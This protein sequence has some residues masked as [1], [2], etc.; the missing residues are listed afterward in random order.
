MNFYLNASVSGLEETK[1]IIE[2][3]LYWFNDKDKAVLHVFRTC[4]IDMSEF[5]KAYPKCANQPGIIYIDKKVKFEELHRYYCKSVLVNEIVDYK[6]G[7]LFRIYKLVNPVAK[8][9]DFDN[10]PI[11]IQYDAVYDRTLKDP[12]RG[13]FPYQTAAV[14]D[15]IDYF[16]PERIIDCGCGAGA[17]YHYLKPVLERNET[18]YTGVDFSRFQVI[19]AM[20]RYK[21]DTFPKVH[22]ALMDLTDMNFEKNSFDFAFTE[23]TLPFIKKA[24]EAILNMNHISKNGFFASLYTVDKKN[25]NIPYDKKNRCYMLN[26][27]STWKF[28]DKITPNTFF[29]P[30][31]NRMTEI[32]KNI[33]EVVYRINEEDQFF[34][35]LGVK[36]KNIFIYPKKWFEDRNVSFKDWNFRPLM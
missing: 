19:K 25:K 2:D 27:G 35:P 11:S 22:F 10:Q 3:F 31:F 13:Y 16:K 5:K 12:Y 32:L 34:S 18:D 36:T 29:L 21:K 24:E 28:M 30:E 1:K 17:N 9:V 15:A 8:E 6:P 14:S 26:T 7:D 33:N 4:D 23:S 20:D